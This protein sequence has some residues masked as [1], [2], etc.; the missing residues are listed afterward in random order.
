MTPARALGA[1]AVLFCATFALLRSTST[2][3][4]VEQRLD[5][6]RRVAADSG[7][8]V[9][10]VMALLD[11]GEGRLSLAELGRVAREVARARDELGDLA[12]AVAAV[13][14]HVA[15]VEELAQDASPAEA[16]RQLRARPEGLVAT[17][18]LTMVDRYAA[19]QR[20]D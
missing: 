14:G 19:A 4:R 9:P 8:R 1:F 5:D 17:R 13:R 11:L 20:A 18:F 15:L 16:L 12:L 7:L 10:E 3:A 2:F 6:V